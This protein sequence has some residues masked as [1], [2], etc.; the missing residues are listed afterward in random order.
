MTFNAKQSPFTDDYREQCFN[1]WFLHGC[2]SASQTPGILSDAPD[3]RRPTASTISHWIESYQWELR[4]QELNAAA[5]AKVNDALV[6]T[7]ADLLKSQFETA[8]ALAKKA[9]EQILAEKIDN[10][11]AA[12]QLYFKATAEART[13][14]GISEFMQKV[15]QMTEAQLQ[16][17][18]S[19]RLERLGV[20]DP[21]PTDE[22]T[23]TKE[24]EKLENK[25]YDGEE[26]NAST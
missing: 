24:K 11:N 2:P 16:N 20:T 3:G 6:S 9:S 25:A 12:V 1:A 18:I 5:L 17:E 21:I 22:D 13:V 26:M 14:M 10:S 15:G 4:A 8:V 19:S 23:S 7:K